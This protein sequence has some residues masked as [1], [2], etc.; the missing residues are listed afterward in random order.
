MTTDPNTRV[1]LKVGEE[2][3]ELPQT[4]DGPHVVYHIAAA[5]AQ[6][7]GGTYIF[8]TEELTRSPFSGGLA[9]RWAD[10]EEE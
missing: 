4:C 6:A 8:R 10:E 7:A 3:A 1:Y 5:L 9:Y 2:W